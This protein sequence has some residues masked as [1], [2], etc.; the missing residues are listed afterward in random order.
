[1]KHYREE[2]KEKQTEAPARRCECRQQ[3]EDPHRDRAEHPQESRE[4][5]SLINMS[6]AGNDTKDNR[7]GIARFAFGCVGCAAGP[8]TSVAAFR[9]FWQGMPAVRA[10]HFIGRILF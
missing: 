3:H 8:I 10:G 4:F 2:V 7:D 5:V 9:I 6:Q 1:M